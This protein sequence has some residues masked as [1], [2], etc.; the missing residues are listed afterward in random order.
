MVKFSHLLPSRKASKTLHPAHCQRIPNA[1][2]IPR[3]ARSQRS[4]L[5]LLF[6]SI[7]A[8]PPLRERCD[9]TGIPEP[10]AAP[11]TNPSR[12][13]QTR[14]AGPPELEFLN[15]TMSTPPGS[16]Q[17]LPQEEPSA[18]REVSPSPSPYPEQTLSSR[19]KSAPQFPIPLL[20]L[21]AQG[22]GVHAG[23]KIPL[24][25]MFIP[26]SILFFFFFNS[27]FFHPC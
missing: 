1:S 25:I 7:P 19:E 12:A 14:T 27:L 10:R 8:H 3:R 13:P 23:F 16:A 21:A 26:P 20:T 17:Q 18:S 15:G 9:P 6:S 2:A 4:G 22:S 11:R 24:E 5:I